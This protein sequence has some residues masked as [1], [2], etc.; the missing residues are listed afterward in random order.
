ME[1]QYY[2]ITTSHRGV[3]YGHLDSHDIASGT[4][5]LRDARMVVYWPAECR[6]VLGL[7]QGGPKK[8]ARIT[9]PVDRIELS[10]V[11]AVIDCPAETNS[12]WEEEW[13]N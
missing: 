6:G 10:H 8:G 3:F 12:I 11:D 1:E 7:A 9:P 2:L 13:W 4:A 5:V